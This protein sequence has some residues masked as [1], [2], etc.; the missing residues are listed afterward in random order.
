MV[1]KLMISVYPIRY[2]NKKLEFL[3]IKR[4]T[5]SFNWQCVTGS[6]G[7]TMGAI[8]HPKG[9][10]PLECA[11]REL[12]EETGY[13]PARI[14]TF[15]PPQEY[16]IQ[17]KEE[18]DELETLPIETQKLVKEIK[19]IFFIARIDQVKDP[20]LNPTE[21]TDWKW[22]SYEVA[23]DLILWTVEK[24]MLSYVYNYLKDNPLK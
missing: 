13:I 17:T 23:Y 4:A 24:R 3:M 12:L 5:I 8:D 6:V 9:E 11:K 2:K 20:I 10:S 7:D 16:Y 22:C 21:H 1:Q 14:I 15:N 19:L 18:I